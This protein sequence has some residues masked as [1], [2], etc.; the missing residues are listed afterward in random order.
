MKRDDEGAVLVLVTIGMAF[1]LL[2]AAFALDFGQ[3]TAHKERAQNTADA[4]ALA[5]ALNCAEGKAADTAPLP[6]LKAGQTESD[7]MVCDYT[8]NEVTATIQSRGILNLFERTNLTATSSGLIENGGVHWRSY[9]LDHRYSRKHRVIAMA[10]A[11]D[12]AVT[13]E[14]TPNYRIWGQPATTDEQRRASRDPVSTMVAMAIDVG[15]NRR[16]SGVYPT[17]DGRFHYLMQLSGGDIDHFRGGGY[18]GEVLK[19]NLA[20]IAVAG[21]E[22]RDAG[23]R[24]IPEGEVWFALM[25]DTLFAPPV[26]ITTP[27]SAGAANIR[28]ASYRRA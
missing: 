28:L 20:Y 24:R 22:R 4:R 6:V 17:F 8:K 11:N 9:N 16:C 2:M 15:Q 5:A 23:R 3:F 18:E 1:L 14:I 25:P 10:A 27:L 26:R 19:C 12:G 7:A 13:A 21:Y